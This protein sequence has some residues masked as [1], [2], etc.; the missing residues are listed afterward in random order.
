MVLY[1]LGMKM[2]KT[3]ERKLIWRFITNKDIIIK[4]NVINDYCIDL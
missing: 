2:N 3:K 4:G 1:E